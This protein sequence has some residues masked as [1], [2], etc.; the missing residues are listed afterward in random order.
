ME[1]KGTAVIAIRDYVKSKYPERFNEWLG[2]LPEG[3]KE[4]YTKAIDASKWYP[5]KEGG[6]D[7]TKKAIDLFHNGD[8][9]KGA[10]EGGK[11]SAQKALTGI[12]K[13][14]VKAA[15]PGYIIERA[16]RIFATYYQPCKMQVLSNKSG[17]ILLEISEMTMSD[18]V[19]EN[20]IAGWIEEALI[21]SGAKNVLVGFPKSFTKGDAVTHLD[22]SWN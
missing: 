22:I 10:R 3:A 17:K 19:I 2:T 20:R 8:Y 6:I 1:I 9:E 13:I 12:Y 21:I 16:T 18:V 7:P 4:I 14:F 5:V 11:Y 15:S